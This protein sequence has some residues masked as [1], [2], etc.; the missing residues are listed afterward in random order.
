MTGYMQMA[1]K[2]GTFG[3]YPKLTSLF[4]VRINQ[5]LK[6]FSRGA[7]PSIT[8]LPMAK[9]PLSKHSCKPSQ[10]GPWRSHRQNQFVGIWATRWRVWCQEIPGCRDSTARSL[11]FGAG[12]Q[13]EEPDRRHAVSGLRRGMI[14]LN[15]T[16]V[17]GAMTLLVCLS[18][19]SGL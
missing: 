9:P 14:L 7:R 3:D 17:I 16:Q 2:T 10:R 4:L 6:Y 5:W 18:G 15:V 11:W 19:V 1:S 8:C 13:P 12:S